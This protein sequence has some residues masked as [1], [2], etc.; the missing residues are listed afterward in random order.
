MGSLGE[1]ERDMFVTHLLLSIV[2]TGVLNRCS[3]IRSIIIRERISL[4]VLLCYIC[5][6]E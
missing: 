1:K 2:R 3:D 4:H 6:G 5:Y